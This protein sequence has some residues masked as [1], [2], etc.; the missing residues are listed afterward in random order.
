[1][2]TDF[3]EGETTTELPVEKP[4]QSEEATVEEPAEEKVIETETP[5]VVETEEPV[6]EAT[7]VKIGEAEYTPEELQ[8]IVSKGTQVKK[9]EEKMP[10]FD[11]DKLMPDYTR[12]S[13]R[14]AQ[15]EKRNTVPKAQADSKEMEEL[16]IDEAQLRALEKAAKHLGFVRQT[17]LVQ[18]SVEAQKETFIARHPE[19]KSDAV[20]G[21]IKWTQLMEK[22]SDFNVYQDQNTKT[23]YGKIDKVEEFLERAH[24]EVSGT[25]QA[26]AVNEKTK[27]AVVT[28]QAQVNLMATGGGAPRGAPQKTPSNTELI[29]KYR[30]AGWSEED[31]KEI[32]T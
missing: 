21:D 26:A 31:I 8:A 6:A 28:K 12:K 29:Q 20:G 7:K 17:D 10:G 18:D 3:T 5:E 24:A 14:L 30:S 2:G 19:Y 11:I 13:Q 16:G 23:W 25:W 4:E 15:F 1:M 22:F 27:Q 9:W 32:L